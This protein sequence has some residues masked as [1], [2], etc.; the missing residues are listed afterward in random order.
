MLYI[1]GKIELIQT[2]NLEFRNLSF[3]YNPDSE[4][5]VLKN[6]NLIIPKNQKLGILGRSGSGK[7]TLAKLL[8]RFYQATEGEILIDDKN[9]NDIDINHLRDT[10]NYVNQ[11]TLLFDKSIYYNIAYGFKSNEKRNS[12][13]DN[14]EENQIS[15]EDKT[16]ILEL[17]NKYDL[18]KVY[19]RLN[20][21]QSKINVNSNNSNVN[22]SSDAEIQDRLEEEA[23]FKEDFTQLNSNSHSQTPS[24]TPSFSSLNTEQI[25]HYKKKLELSAGPRGTNLSLGMQ[26]VTIVTRGILKA[27]KILI[28]D[29]PLAGLDKVTREKVIKMIINETNNKTLIIITHDKEIIP[30]LEKVVDLNNINQK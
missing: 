7:S 10:I 2:G 15:D 17:L 4:E 28:F 9:I 25:N 30:H 1:N 19:D 11:N 6:I 20:D 27:S 14:L 26:K 5:Y 23:I 3:K 13:T 22:S 24:Y 21:N 16:K 12:S 29:E 18:L 8:I